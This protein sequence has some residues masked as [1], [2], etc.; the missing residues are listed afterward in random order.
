MK[1][2]HSRKR[3]SKLSIGHVAL[4]GLGAAAMLNAC[5]AEAPADAARAEQVQVENVRIDESGI[6][7]LAG[8]MV[9]A[10]VEVQGPWVEPHVQDFANA[11]CNRFNA[12]RPSTYD[13]H[14][15]RGASLALDILVSGQWG[16]P[17]NE[18]DGLN[19]GWDVARYALAD[20]DGRF[21]VDYVIWQGRINY[22]DGTGWHN[23]PNQGSV[24]GNHL[25]HV[26][27]SFKPM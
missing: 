15:T 9:Q 20:H 2:G 18:G 22:K 8:G 4:L 11:V 10:Q 12:C 3:L 5:G 1:N 14:P 7:A 26:H 27:V 23:Y 21:R 24:T 17:A 16:D 13:G 25:D 19:K 6:T